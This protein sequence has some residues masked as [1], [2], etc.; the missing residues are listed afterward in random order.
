[1]V[2]GLMLL[3]GC[4]APAV[5]GMVASPAATVGAAAAALVAGTPPATTTPAASATPPPTP[6]PDSSPAAPPPSPTPRVVGQSLSGT[7]RPAATGVITPTAT[8]PPPTFT[9]PPPPPPVAGEHL[10]LQRPVPGAAAQ[11]T[12][13]SYPYGSTRGGMLRPHHGVEFNVPTGTS[14]LAVAAGMVVAAGSDSDV[15]Y[16][17]Q[18]DFYGNVVVLELS[19]SSGGVPVFVLYGHLS[20]VTATVGQIAAAGDV[21]GR[22]G[23]SGVADG[24]HLHL[25]VRVGENSYLNTRNPLLWLGP[26][27]GTGVVAGRVVDAGGNSLYEVPVSLRRVDAPAP[28]TATVSYAADGPNADG[29]LGENF[30]MDDVVPGFY[31]VIVGDGRRRQTAE[32]WVFPG[33]VNWVEVTLNP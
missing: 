18:T 20:E 29:T 15:A 12:D 24:P 5:G 31:Q 2:F 9:P 14:V 21:L 25:E 27:P 11:W 19:G 17:P 32:L 28:Y 13:K 1:M 4:G 22:S 7:P 33:R 6:T 8:T 30:V 16:G 23:D 10:F 3:A 26:L